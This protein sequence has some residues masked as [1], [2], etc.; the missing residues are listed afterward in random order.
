MEEYE[1]D[2]EKMN[3]GEAVLLLIEKVE[4][5]ESAYISIDSDIRYEEGRGER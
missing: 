4:R 5:L 3:L 2:G 1:I